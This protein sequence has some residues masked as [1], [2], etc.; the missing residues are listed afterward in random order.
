MI[1]DSFALPCIKTTVQDARAGAMCDVSPGVMQDVNLGVMH[2]VGPAALTHAHPPYSKEKIWVATNCFN[3]DNLQIKYFHF[4][5]SVNYDPTKMNPPFSTYVRTKFFCT[6][7]NVNWVTTNKLLL[8]C[9]R[10][11]C[12]RI[13][14]TNQGTS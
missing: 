12:H 7:G 4:S 2:K 8:S 10:S 11:G 6:T 1:F 9:M 13:L 3:S 14:S 5:A